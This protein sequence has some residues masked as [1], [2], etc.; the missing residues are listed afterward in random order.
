V[1]SRINPPGLAQLESTYPEVDFVGGAFTEATFAESK[2]LVVSPGISVR[3]GCFLE[4][5][6][7]GVEIVGDIELFARAVKKPVIAITGSNGKS[8]VTELIG[9]MF[10]KAHVN[11]G[12]GGNLGPPA[13]DLLT[14]DFDAYVL[15]LSSFQLETTSSLKPSVAILLN[16]S[17][18]HMDRYESLEDYANVKATIFNDAE[19]QV[20][21]RDDP[22]TRAGL[23]KNKRQVS[24]G[25]STPKEG[26]Y[27]LVDKA[28]VQWLACGNEL[29]IQKNDLSLAGNHNVLNVLASMACADC[30]G[31]PRQSTLEAI[32]E[33]KG[34]SHR[35]EIVLE[36]NGILWI[37]DSKGTNVGATLA[38][39]K[40]IEQP[41]ILIAGGDGKGADFSPLKEAVKNKVKQIV[42][43]GKDAKKISDA[44]GE[45]VPVSFATDMQA[46]VL[47]ANELA[48]KG[49]C[50][51]LSPAC[52]SLDMF[53]DYKH[54]GNEFSAE[55]KRIVGE[56]NI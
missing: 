45:V 33:F 20:F 56:G 38:A 44:V 27:G 17:E 8:T 25:L 41:I 15:E 6:K 46:A 39:I 55:V 14:S 23:R 21:C 49:D 4:A 48:V 40:G 53:T 34:L 29:L 42:L 11:T 37:N 43:I 54:R 52:A 31:L 5:K 18:D 3:Q 2:Q 32:R 28:G 47:V 10:R 16:I 26:E 7:H 24:F 30:F 1:D 22:A 9:L 51:L 35:C 12:V 19:S 50:V 13:L 36:Q